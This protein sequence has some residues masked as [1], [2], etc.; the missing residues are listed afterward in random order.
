GLKG[1]AAAVAG[2]L[3][4]PIGAIV[5]GLLIGV[6]ESL[7]AGYVASGFKD[8]V[9]FILLILVLILRPQGLVGR[10]IVTRV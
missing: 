4:N 6:V 7:S 1:F 5:G 9:G 2:G 10:A 8:A 3:G